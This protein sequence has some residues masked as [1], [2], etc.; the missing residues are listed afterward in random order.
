METKYTLR[1]YL[2]VI[3]DLLEGAMRRVGE[4]KRMIKGEE[5]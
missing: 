5:Y 3:V 2:I 4:E 1:T